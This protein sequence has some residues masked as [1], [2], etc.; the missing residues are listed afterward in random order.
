MDF[1]IIEDNLYITRSVG[2]KEELVSFEEINF[3]NMNC[4]RVFPT[5]DPEEYCIQFRAKQPLRQRQKER[6]VVAT[7]RLSIQELEEILLYMKAKTLT[8]V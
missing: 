8:N 1:K 5:N 4:I 2:E 7:V 3:D 6:N